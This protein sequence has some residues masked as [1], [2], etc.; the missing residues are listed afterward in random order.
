MEENNEPT[1]SF[2]RMQNTWKQMSFSDN[3]TLQSIITAVKVKHQNGDWDAFMLECHVH[4]SAHELKKSAGL[5]AEQKIAAASV[6]PDAEEKKRKTKRHNDD[7]DNDEEEMEEVIIN[8]ID[9]SKYIRP[10]GKLSIP[11]RVWHSSKTTSRF[12]SM[13]GKY[14]RNVD[15]DTTHRRA[16]KMRRAEKDDGDGSDDDDKGNN[17]DR[18]IKALEARLAALEGE[19]EDYKGSNTGGLIAGARGSR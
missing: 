15:T 18:V 8:G 12:K 5:L 17:K 9:Y 14:N 6:T 11:D 3:P 1:T 10:L 19:R 16:H 2:T 7:E 13:V 4:I